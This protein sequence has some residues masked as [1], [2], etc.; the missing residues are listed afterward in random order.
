MILSE[1][2]YLNVYIHMYKYSVDGRKLVLSVLTVL[3]VR[4][5]VTLLEQLTSASLGFPD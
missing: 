5:G 3:I 2:K 1:G 4:A